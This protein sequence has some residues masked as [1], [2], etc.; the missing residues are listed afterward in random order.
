MSGQP[1]FEWRAL[2]FHSLYA[3]F[4]A[5]FL[6]FVFVVFAYLIVNEV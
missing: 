5:L 1:A 4:E 6:I 2:G 3:N